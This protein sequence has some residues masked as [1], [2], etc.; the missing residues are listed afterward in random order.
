MANAYP[1]P[2][3][4]TPLPID[5]AA[6]HSIE[7]ALNAT[8]SQSERGAL[9]TIASR[10]MAARSIELSPPLAT[11]ALDHLRRV[12]EAAELLQDA[13]QALLEG[14]GAPYR[15]AR[16]FDYRLRDMY[17]AGE[18]PANL[19]ALFYIADAPKTLL[20]AAARVR[21][22]LF[23]TSALRGVD[24]KPVN[25]IE[26]TTPRFAP[27]IDPFDQEGTVPPDA[28][29]WLVWALADF[30]GSRG[31]AIS[32]RGDVSDLGKI[33]PFVTLVS[34]IQR[35]F[36]VEFRKGNA[37]DGAL[38]REISRALRERPKRDK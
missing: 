18:V 37:S 29:T 35:V 16:L 22:N 8:L 21:E 15:V 6:W 11:D 17:I 3:G 14:E 32:A 5:E 25:E 30:A 20:A 19:A 9:L 4:L 13:L 26:T 12:E 38:S 23:N 36:P 27:S 28:W 2:A 34:A 24:G 10:Y 1:M 31:M 33:S 7:H